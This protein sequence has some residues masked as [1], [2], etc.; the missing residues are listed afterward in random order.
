MDFLFMWVDQRFYPSSHSVLEW[1]SVQ[2]D[3][4]QAKV[5]LLFISLLHQRTP[6]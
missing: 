2:S 6:H 5:N 4:D 3:K 1:N